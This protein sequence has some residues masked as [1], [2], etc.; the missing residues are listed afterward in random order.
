VDGFCV[1]H[2]AG[3]KLN[4][5]KL[6]ISTGL[7]LHFKRRRLCKTTTTNQLNMSHT[8]SRQR[9]PLKTE[10]LKSTILKKIGRTEM[11]DAFLIAVIMTL[12]AIIVVALS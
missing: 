1:R 11:K 7:R 9:K 8:M 12:P 3:A 5:T 4:R 2:G 6:L 10:G